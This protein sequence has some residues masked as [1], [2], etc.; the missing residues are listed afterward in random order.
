MGDLLLAVKMGEVVLEGSR[1]SRVDRRVA[2]TDFSWSN[3]PHAQAHSSEGREQVNAPS[4]LIS[5]PPSPGLHH[6]L[7]AFSSRSLLCCKR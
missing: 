7:T 4:A 6:V 1:V 2:L 5:Q 3:C